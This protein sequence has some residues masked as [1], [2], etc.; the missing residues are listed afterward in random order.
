[1]II[2]FGIL[3]LI[4]KRKYFEG[5]PLLY[6]LEPTILLLFLLLYLRDILN[7]RKFQFARF[8]WSHTEFNG[9]IISAD[10]GSWAINASF[11]APSIINASLQPVFI[12]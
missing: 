10:F 3:N 11:V 7:T 6:T 5:A 8:R 4:N 2:L 1:M 9:R 12:P